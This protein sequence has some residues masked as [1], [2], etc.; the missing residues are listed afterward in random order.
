MKEREQPVAGRQ[1]KVTIDLSRIPE[2]MFD[3]TKPLRVAAV[4]GD[5]IM[6]QKVITPSK[7]PNPRRFDVEL[8][9]DQEQD[10]VAGAN[11]IVAPADDERNL[12]SKYAAR[13]F[14]SGVNKRLD[15]GVLQISPAI[16]QWWRFCWLPRTYHITGRVVRQESDCTHPVGAANVEIYDVDYCWWW[17]SEDLI[18]SGTTDADGFFDITFTWCV[19][20]WCL[21]T[22]R[23]PPIYLDPDLRDRIHEIIRERLPFPPIPPDDPWQFEQILRQTGVSLPDAASREEFSTRSAMTRMRAAQAADLSVSTAALSAPLKASAL[24]SLSQ[25]NWRDLLEPIIFWPICEDPC[26]WYPDVRLR[27]TQNQPGSGTVEIFRENVWQTHWNLSTDLLNLS[28]HANAQALYS[29]ACSPDPILGNCMLFERVGWFN[30]STIYQPDLTAGVSYGTTPDRKQRLGYT[31]S[32]DRAWCETLGVHGDFGL[33]AQVD[34]YQVQVAKW[35]AADRDAWELDHTYVLPDARYAAVSADKLGG[36]D[37]LYAELQSAG[38]WTYYL[39]KSEGFAPQ[40]VGGIPGVYKSRQRFEQEY[41]NAHGGANPAPDFVSGWYWDTTARTR[42][43]H[44][45]TTKFS[46]GLYS[47]RLVGYHQTGVDGSGQPV[48]APVNMGLPGGVLKRCGGPSAPVK[49]DLVTLM[50]S[51]AGYLAPHKP[52][53]EIKSFKKNGVTPI[54]EC[55]ILVLNPDPLVGDTV[56]IEFEASDAAGNLEQ[57]AVNFYRGASGPTSA[58]GAPG[59]SM[60]GTI[61]NG[62]DYLDVIAAVPAAAPVWT[63]GSWVLTVPASFF[64]GLGGSCA[65][66]LRVGAWDRQT[67]GWSAGVGW[68]AVYTEQ[69]RAFTVVLT[70]DKMKYCGQL[71]CP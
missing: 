23:R 16:Y 52:K 14:V 43:F 64:V 70:T 32:K 34:Y 57:Y 67:D 68:G 3:P 60:T 30:V 56:A 44:V 47:F 45:D 28:L 40:T 26:D 49:A 53:V 5:Q 27:V 36:F 39:W 48:L 1:G 50:I 66:N 15:G 13:K 71:G 35:N 58:L 51:N 8:R 17:Y 69:N 19:P 46:D 25:I 63:G 65:Y 31:V 11:V 41:R 2:D 38:G 4:Y 33:A 12:F 22:F 10:G 18:A 54:A 37:R 59:V 7:Q 55:D 6:D 61:P 21:F 62:P 42:L 24:T 20:L 9:F 29:D